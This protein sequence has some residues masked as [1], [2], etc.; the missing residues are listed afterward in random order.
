[1][2]LITEKKR[3]R[4]S[5]R[6]IPVYKVLVKYGDKLI[7]TPY[8]DTVVKLN[9]ILKGKGDNIKREV[10]DG[11]N[12]GSGYIHTFKNKEDAMELMEFLNNTVPRSLQLIYNKYE[13][14]RVGT[15]FL[16]EG[17]IPAFTRYYTGLTMDNK[18]SYA[19]KRIIY[20][21]R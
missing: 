6:R 19:S 8:T 7:F 9:K 16:V 10:T 15:Y 3:P 12:I 21:R 18:A 4:I 14:G 5:S 13:I 17:Y 1:M 2:C 20:I 11:Y